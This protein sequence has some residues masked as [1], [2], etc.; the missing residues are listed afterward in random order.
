MPTTA[1]RPITTA[2]VPAISIP[3]RRRISTAACAVAGR[4]PSY[5]SRSSP[6]LRGWMPSMS[7]AGSIASMTARSRIVGGSGIWTMTPST[8]GRR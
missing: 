2:S 1:D 8:S 3:E 4:K 5:P 6:A 7:L